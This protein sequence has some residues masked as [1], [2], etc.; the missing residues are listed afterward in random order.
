MA[1]RVLFGILDQYA[2]WEAAYLSS[3]LRMLAP[4]SYHIKTVSL[5][6]DCVESIG[7]FYVRPDYDL[8]T[9]P[10]DYEAL[11]LIGGMSWRTQAA[12]RWKP[13]VQ[14]CAENGR[15]LGGICDAAGF[16]ATAGLLNEV[17]HTGNGLENL[18]QWA[19]AAYT[20][21]ANYLLEPAVY[22][23]KIVTANGTAALEFA[24][25]VLLALEAAPEEKIWEWYHFHKLG[26]Y[27]APVPQF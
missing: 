26:M 19:G 13:R 20:G 21:E 27:Q 24:R 12:E 25:E 16:L 17:Q 8:S 3:A 7:G 5:T 6:M 2:D 10:S 22:H 18:Q 9:M 15:L 4:D 23:Q 1:K 14:E 11:L